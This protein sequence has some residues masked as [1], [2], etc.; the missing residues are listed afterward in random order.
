MDWRSF[1]KQKEKDFQ[2]ILR[3]FKEELSE[4]RTSRP[5]TKLVED[6]EV[7]C[8]GKKVPLK[9]LGMISLSKEREIIIE[10][11]DRSY[12]EGI[13]KAIHESDL[14]LSP[15][16]TEEMV[17]VPFPSLT[18]ERR[19][20]YLRLLAGK[21]EEARQ[22]IREVRNKVRKSI[23]KAESKGEMGEDDKFRAR[24][25]LQEMVDDYNEKVEEM[26]EKKAELIKQ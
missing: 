20:K 13:E 8:F 25:K 12:L 26:A 7:Q 11:F 5:S 16:V 24:E 14:G 23:D 21:K 17:R 6:L 2:E 9:S 22:R 18:S 15:I 10:P 3:G 4:I 1:L 19:E